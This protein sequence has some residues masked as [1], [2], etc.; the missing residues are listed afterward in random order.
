MSVPLNRSG[1]PENLQFDLDLNR[2]ALVS[3]RAKFSG[4]L[5]AVDLERLSSVAEYVEDQERLYDTDQSISA[6]LIPDEKIR[7]EYEKFLAKYQRV[8]RDNAKDTLEWYEKLRTAI[9]P[10]LAD[11][12]DIKVLATKLQKVLRQYRRRSTGHL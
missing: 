2:L 4:I 8:R 12:E 10:L 6:E 1:I 7:K 5:E 9:Q 11:T 3:L